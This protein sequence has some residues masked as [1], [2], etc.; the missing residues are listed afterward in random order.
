MRMLTI[1]VL[2]AATG[3]CVTF[4]EPPADSST[5]E[6][7]DAT[8]SA[9]SGPGPGST[10]PQPTSGLPSDDLPDPA[11]D[12]PPPDSDSD[13]EP[14]TGEPPPPGP[15]PIVSELTRFDAMDLGDCD[16]DGRV[17]LVTADTGE[18]PR[19]TF[20]RGAGDGSFAG[21]EPV[22]SELFTFSSFMLADITGDGRADVVTR[23]TGFPP[24]VNVYPADGAGGFAAP[25]TTELPE[26]DV[27]HAADMNG[28]G[29]ADLVTGRGDGPPPRITVWPGGPDG[30]GDGALFNG[31]V[32]T[33]TGLRAGD[34]DG[35]GHADVATAGTGFP[36]RLNVYPGD[37]LGGLGELVVHELKTFAQFDLGDLDGDGRGDVV[38]DVPGNAWVFALY[39]SAPGRWAGPT[40]LEG[41]NFVGF[42]LGDLD[43]DGHADIVARPPGEPPRVEVYLAPL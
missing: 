42:E 27:M 26:F 1:C 3:A 18:P 2:S 9:T 32:F 12:P 6:T 20:Y 35:D 30:V 36:P 21:D 13:S 24:R 41:F 34:L 33:Y 8:A 39:R 22:V 11:G 29:R 15:M 38:A 16:G 17:D 23:G 28:D 19:V 40:L 14:P 43:G 25:T 7:S 10:D 31:E 37:G 5:G 4:P